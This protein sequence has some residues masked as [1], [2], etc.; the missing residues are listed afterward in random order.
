MPLLL[1]PVLTRELSPP[2][3]GVVAMFG[4]FLSIFGAFTG[5]SVHGAIGVRYFQLDSRALAEYVG[6]CIIILVI[7]TAAMLLVVTALG[8]ELERVSG[9]PTAW[10][11]VAVV[12]S[13]L[14]VLG[15]IRLSLWQAAKQAAKYGAFQISQSLLNGGLSLLLV[16]A[17]GL[18]WRGRVLGQVAAIA[19]FS[20]VA[21]CLLRVDGLV[22][23]SRAWREQSRDAIKFGVPLIPH[24]LGALATATAGQTI[25]MNMF[26]AAETGL[27]VVGAQ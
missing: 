15:A 25:V 16:L 21:F 8:T 13:G 27:Y 10:L 4:I 6:S 2:D 20:V 17:A 18:G 24:V 14:Q 26:G 1:L 5:L 9:V 22:A 23:K 3:Y 11:L 19:L 12:I 7:A